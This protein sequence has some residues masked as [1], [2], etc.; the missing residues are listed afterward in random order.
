MISLYSS[1]VIRT[2]Q[3]K[4]YVVIIVYLFLMIILI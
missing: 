3:Y 2:P 1:N 4:T